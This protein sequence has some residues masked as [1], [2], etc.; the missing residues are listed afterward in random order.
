MRL[1]QIIGMMGIKGEI[2]VDLRQ[3]YIV[4]IR[5]LSFFPFLFFLFTKSYISDSRSEMKG[6][7]KTDLSFLVNE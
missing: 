4:F 1:T 7:I 6:K 5:G 3:Y 2:I